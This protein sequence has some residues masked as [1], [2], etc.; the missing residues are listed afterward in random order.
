MPAYPRRIIRSAKRKRTVSARIKDG[1]LEIQA[2]AKM[3]EKELRSIIERF[4]ERLAKREA[5][6]QTLPDD[7]ALRK[8]AVALNRRW[9]SGKLPLERLHRITFV[10]NQDKRWGSCTSADGTVRLSHRL[11]EFPEWV[12]D[13][14]LAHELAHLVHGDHSAA[15]WE[16]VGNYPLTERARGFLIAASLL[17]GDEGE[18]D[19]GDADDSVPC[20]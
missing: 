17:S 10:T 12:L 15:F 8:R 9:F 3:S 20:T 19:L 7:D 14:V 13:Y 18:N 2:P 6:I 11:R 5:E 1:V 16:L 4:E